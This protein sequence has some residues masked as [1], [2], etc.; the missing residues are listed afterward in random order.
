[1]IDNSKVLVNKVVGLQGA[2]KLSNAFLL[3]G[4]DGFPTVAV[5]YGS[6][7]VHLH[8]TFYPEKEAELYW[9][10]KLIAGEES[11]LIIFIGFGLGYHVKEL[12]KIQPKSKIVAL[13]LH[14]GIWEMAVQNMDLSYLDKAT[15]FLALVGGDVEDIR[16]ALLRVFEE[17]RK[18]GAV[19]S[20]KVYIHP[21]FEQCIE[22]YA[23]ILQAVRLA[24]SG[25]AG[26][27]ATLYNTTEEWYDNNLKNLKFAIK[28]PILNNCPA[29]FRG[30]PVIVI[31]AGP[32]LM[33]NMDVLKQIY[34]D[35]SAILIC[36]GTAYPALV[37]NGINPHFVGTVDASLLNWELINIQEHQDLHQETIL[38]YD[39][40]TNPWIL[41]DFKGERVWVYCDSN[42]WHGFY[43]DCWQ[44]GNPVSAVASV[45]TY[46]YIL[47]LKFGCGPIVLVGNDYAYQ[48]D[49]VRY[50]KDTLADHSIEKEHFYAGEWTLN[51]AGDKVFSP[52]DY[53]P[54]KF[55]VSLMAK[56]IQGIN[57]YNAAYRGAVIEGVPYKDL[58]ELA[59]QFSNNNLKIDIN[60]V[61]AQISKL[62]PTIQESI[63]LANALLKEIVRFEDRL[64]ECRKGKNE[65]ETIR[66]A[67]DFLYERDGKLIERKIWPIVHSFKNDGIKKYL[68][69]KKQRSNFIYMSRLIMEKAKND[70]KNI[71][72]ELQDKSELNGE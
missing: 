17:L 30:C 23:D 32:S 19:K 22:E 72:V 59:E 54:A 13:E 10:K 63:D 21:V 50:A 39:T 27:T 34:M 35:K 44:K 70:I 5:K 38:L 60:Y 31:G 46:L 4:N 8:S 71:V 47:A 61:K 24:I 12:L 9:Q 62:S 15:F 36:A 64:A 18:N 53:S 51:Y 68:S 57:T 7:L 48:S 20:L 66:L 42:P 37:K 6:G 3:A 11:D 52:H 65:K 16:F 43:R 49:G 33:E 56:S 14:R 2:V 69:E 55:Y 1:M 45:S 58:A 25:F 26:S 29:I 41:R 28:D 40:I 67:E